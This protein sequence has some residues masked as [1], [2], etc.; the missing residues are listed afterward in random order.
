M[1]HSPKHYTEM[2]RLVA[3]AGKRDWDELTAERGAQLMEGLAVMGCKRSGWDQACQ[4]G[5]APGCRSLR[6]TPSGG[7]QV[8]EYPDLFVFAAGHPP[9]P[10][11]HPVPGGQGLAVP[12]CQDGKY[13]SLVLQKGLRLYAVGWLERPGFVTGHVPDV[14]VEALVAAHA[15]KIVSDGTRGIH[16]CTLC[17][18]ILP[19]LQWRDQ[20]IQL[21]G[22]GHYLIQM[23]KT[24]Y[25]APELLLHY[26]R[27][28]S[29]CPPQE[30]LRGTIHGAFLGV[31]DLEITWSSR[32]R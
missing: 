8:L 26:I 2:C 25:I 15:T 5:P 30:F 22:H 27:E 13:S 20:T 29:Y 10:Y 28:H 14:C 32:V 19:Q 31:D 6:L 16:T 1:D 11:D 4:P 3:G 23:D 12:Y 21:Q 9:S 17:G 18:E 24:V 7:G